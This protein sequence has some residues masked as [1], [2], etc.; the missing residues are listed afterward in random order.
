MRKYVQA[1]DLAE[2]LTHIMAADSPQ[3]TE[4]YKEIVRYRLGKP[5]QHAEVIEKML[6]WPR[7]IM[8]CLINLVLLSMAAIL[9]SQ[10]AIDHL[11]AEVSALILGSGFLYAVYTVSLLVYLVCRYS[12]CRTY[13]LID[14]LFARKILVLKPDRKSVV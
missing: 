9:Y 14:E 12:Q 8:L 3:L 6:F 5:G 10:G 4:M 13:V 1:S 2:V 11:P 7:R